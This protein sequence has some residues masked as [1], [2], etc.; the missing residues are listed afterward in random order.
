ME[1]RFN[2]PIERLAYGIDFHEI[3]EVKKAI[4]D[5]ADVNANHP[6]HYNYQPL[7]LQAVIELNAEAFELMAQNGGNVCA[8]NDA[9]NLTYDVAEEIID[10]MQ[11]ILET[12]KKYEKPFED[13]SEAQNASN[14]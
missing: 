4:A 9:G 12:I 11:K 2:T 7:M 6:D 1:R 13:E 3:E 14:S 8:C 10:E 5:G